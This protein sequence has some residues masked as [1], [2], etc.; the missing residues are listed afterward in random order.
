MLTTETRHRRMSSSKP[1]RQEQLKRLHLQLFITIRIRL[2]FPQCTHCN[3][4]P[5][6]A[7]AQQGH[8]KPLPSVASAL[9]AGV[10]LKHVKTSLAI[11]HIIWV[12]KAKT[13]QWAGK[14]CF[15]F[16]LQVLV[17]FLCTRVT[18]VL[19]NDHLK[20]CKAMAQHLRLFWFTW[21]E[22]SGLQIVADYTKNH[23][24]EKEV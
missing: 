9:I 3:W 19:Q 11:I 20:N 14:K 23:G 16:F 6:P 2:S 10:A 4:P 8:W 17:M 13:F 5:D 12:L 1:P 22:G 21:M 24:D 7:Y 15:H 18:F